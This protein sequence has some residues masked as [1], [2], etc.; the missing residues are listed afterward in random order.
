MMSGDVFLWILARVFG[1]SS[2]AALSISLLTGVALR[3]ALLS[4]LA[5]NRAVRLAHEF[6]AMLWIPLGALHVLSL[7]MDRTS[8]IAPLDAIVPFQLHYATV[9]VGLGT[10]S[11]DLIVLVAV[12]GW[13][14]RRMDQSIWRLIHRLSYAAFALMFLH[15]VLSG[16]DFSDPAVSAITWST[17]F[18]LGLLSLSRAVWGRVPA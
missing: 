7:M 2:F 4:F 1:L 5:T 17:A 15:A 3:S 12:T 13:L 6:T 10:V 8:R 9:A 18:A 11:L 14:R 16:T